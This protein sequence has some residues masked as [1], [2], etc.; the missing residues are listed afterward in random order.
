MKNKKLM[1]KNGFVGGAIVSTVGIVISKILGIVYVIPFHALVGPLGGAL[2]GYAYTLYTFFLA[3]NVYLDV[4]NLVP[5]HA[6]ISIKPDKS[7]FLSIEYPLEYKSYFSVQLPVLDF[8]L[9]W[10]ISPSEKW[11]NLW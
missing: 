5:F 2:Y 11:L 9:H 7:R 3:K 8:D 4:V 1:K 6:G 10:T